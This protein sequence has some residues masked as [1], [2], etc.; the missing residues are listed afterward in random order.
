MEKHIVD[1]SPSEK[2]DLTMG[3]EQF[4]LTNQ[5]KL[6]GSKNLGDDH[7]V[8]SWM[9]ICHGWA[10]GSVMAPKPIAPVTLV[11]DSGVTKWNGTRPMSG[12]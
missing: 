3:D 7:D 1:L 8:E 5:Q 6:E 4:S 9:G 2:Y 11:G 10:A 12:R